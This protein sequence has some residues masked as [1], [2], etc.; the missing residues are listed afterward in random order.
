MALFEREFVTD[1]G[2]KLKMR[3]AHLRPLN[4]SCP[5]H[6]RRVCGTCAGF[7]AGAPMRANDQPCAHLQVTVNGTR[8]AA[9]CKRWTRKLPPAAIQ[10]NPDER[11]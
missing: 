1:Q 7:P 4:P 11:G 5:L 2:R 8:C 3:E 10:P 6:L 9:N